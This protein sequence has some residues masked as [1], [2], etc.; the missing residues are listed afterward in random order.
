MEK[1]DQIVNKSLSFLDN[2]YASLVVNALV[3]MYAAMLAPKISGKF[4]EYF[5][6]PVVKVIGMFLIIYLARKEPS[7]A[8]LV[9]VG[10]LITIQTVN[11]MLVNGK[12]KDVVGLPKVVKNVAP[13]VVKEVAQAAAPQVVQAPPQEDQAIEGFGGLEA[14]DPSMDFAGLDEAY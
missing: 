5:D 8:L 7:L 10:L 6:L 9:A 13:V 11:K 4:A 2:K 3:I 12:I 1:F 14:Y